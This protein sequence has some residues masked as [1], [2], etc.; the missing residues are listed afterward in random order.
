MLDTI[1]NTLGVWD[2]VQKNWKRLVNI[3]MLSDDIK[4][5]LPEASKEFEE[6]N[7]QFRDVMKEVEYTPILKEVCTEERQFKLT[8][9]LA[10]IDRCEK[11]LNAYL[12]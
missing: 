3:F 1:E 5:Q 9:I 12:E 10:S 7:T 4:N 11:E 6:K 2:K 8:G